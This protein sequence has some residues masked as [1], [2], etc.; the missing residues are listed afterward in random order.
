MKVYSIG[1]EA[2]CDIVINDN[3]DAT[4]RRH[5]TL[6]VM[7]SGKMTITDQSR[8]GTYVNGI[9]MSELVIS[10][11][12]KIQPYLFYN[13][14]SLKTV[15]I[16]GNVSEIGDYAFFGCSNLQEVK[17]KKNVNRIGSK[18]FWNCAKLKD[19]YIYNPDSNIPNSYETISGSA[20]IHGYDNSTAQIY[21]GNYN[22]SFALIE[23]KPIILGDA[24]G[25]GD[26]NITDAT[27]IQRHLAEIPVY[28]YI[29]EAADTDGDGQ[30]SII[31]V[32]MIQR[33][34]AQLPCSEGI[35][36]VIK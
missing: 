25:D 9:K 27:C 33:Y 22:R 36:E 30:V 28:E 5:A 26:L 6:T 23:D 10:N 19:I 35:G 32:T 31:D 18:C 17:L 20:T 8:N 21:A 24:D 34:L 2:G 16:N 4:S 13:C 3:S 1:R 15:I 12:D 7:P 29:E 14:K 11:T